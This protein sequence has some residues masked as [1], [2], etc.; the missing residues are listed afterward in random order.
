MS[1]WTHPAQIIISL[2]LLHVWP[3]YFISLL[4]KSLWQCMKMA[5]TLLSHVP[6]CNILLHTENN[7]GTRIFLRFLVCSITHTLLFLFCDFIHIE[8][9]ISR[10][11][12][13]IHKFLLCNLIKDGCIFILHKSSS[14][15]L[16]FFYCIH[17]LI[18]CY[19]FLH[20]RAAFTTEDPAVSAKTFPHWEGIICTCIEVYEIQHVR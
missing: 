19:I 4:R 8:R 1:A 10:R 13:L 2:C 7:F 18:V 5:N 3:I 12:I 20:L 6:T 14:S 15:L 16:R 11:Q 17:C 9:L